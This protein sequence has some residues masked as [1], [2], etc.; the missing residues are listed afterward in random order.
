L[1]TQSENRQAE[2][3]P[4]GSGRPLFKHEIRR[5]GRVVATLEAHQTPEGVTVDSHVFP[6]TEP[7]GGEGFPRPFAFASLEHARRFVD[8]ALVAF[9]YLNCSVG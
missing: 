7:V 1:S 4:A 3:A 6:V 5:D 2:P 9:E 8:E